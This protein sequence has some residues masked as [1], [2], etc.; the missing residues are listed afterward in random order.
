MSTPCFIKSLT[1]I[2]H[3]LSFMNATPDEKKTQLIKDLQKVNEN[4]P[5]S[6][7]IPFVNNS[8]RNFAV[9][10]IAAL[11]SRIFQTKSRCP[12][13]LCIEVYRPDEL[14]HHREA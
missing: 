7:Y 8:A 14:I 10:H 13:L 1:D 6:V 12:V 2:S 3:K 4:L 9:L 5:A 11:E